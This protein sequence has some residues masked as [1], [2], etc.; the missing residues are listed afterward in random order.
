MKNALSIDVED[1]Y[2][3]MLNVPSDKW[4]FYEGRLEKGMD[5]VMNLLNS[6][7]IKATFFVLGYAAEK[8]PKTIKE[9]AKNG[10]EVASHGYSHRPA[11]AQT[12]QEFKDDVLRSK[13]ILEGIINARVTGYRAPFFSITKNSLWALEILN[14]LG[15][16]YDSSVFPVKNFLY[17]IPDAP[18]TVYRPVQGGL[19][20]FPLSVIRRLGMNIPVCGGFYMRAM[21]YNFIKYGISSFNRAGGPAVIYLHPWELDEE[22]PKIP[23]PLKWKIIHE[24]N[25][26]AMKKK[27]Q[28]L[29]DDFQFTTISEVLFGK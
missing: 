29:L 12:P 2:Q 14:E 18:H 6:R 22:K 4:V 19:I 27:F 8:Y 21:P 9:I 11:F 26:A 13:G 20:E 25:I 17:G 1:W 5:I 3:G 10:H 24:Y 28:R 23:L 16:L 15:F 7:G